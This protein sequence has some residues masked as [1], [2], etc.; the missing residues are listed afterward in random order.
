MLARFLF[1]GL[2]IMG[3]MTGC[4][5]CTQQHDPTADR[6]LFKNEAAIAN[7]EHPK[8]TA[9]GKIPAP[10][11]AAV[12]SK[13]PGTQKY[14]QFC[15]PCHGVNGDGNGPGA[16][17]LNPKPRNFKDL[18]WQASVN[19]QRIA[20]VIKEGGASVGL[21][22]SMAAWGAV[23]SDSDMPALVAIVRGFAKA[24]P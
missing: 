23:I 14:E 4:S 20:K 7:S 2:G 24:S 5:Q 9:E 17:A 12:V 16:Q 18:K 15:V 22:A 21:S 11:G 3:L 13:D 10:K 8:L 6:E 1:V 19:D